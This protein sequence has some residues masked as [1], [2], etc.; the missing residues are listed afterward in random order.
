MFDE[1]IKKSK[2]HEIGMNLDALS[3]EELHKRIAELQSE[4]ARLEATIDA[5]SAT[6]KAADAAFKI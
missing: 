3:V 5:K 1:E 4:I 6:R 2:G